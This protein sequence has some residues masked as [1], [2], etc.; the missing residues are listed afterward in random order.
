VGGSLSKGANVSTKP[1]SQI[2]GK[3]QYHPADQCYS[4]H[5]ATI[6]GYIPCQ[7]VPKKKFAD[8]VILTDLGCELGFA[9][10]K[11]QE[12]VDY[13]SVRLHGPFVS[14]PVTCFLFMIDHDGHHN[15]VWFYA[16]DKGGE[17][18]RQGD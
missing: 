9:W 10:K 5:I 18:A 11:T 16:T 14:D 4:G 1:D 17:D 3:F 8:F 7:I 12:G 15:L 13:L 6:S 2:I